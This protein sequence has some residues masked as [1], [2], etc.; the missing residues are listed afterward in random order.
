LH[1]DRVRYLVLL[2]FIAGCGL[3]LDLDPPDPD[4]GMYTPDSG[5][6][7][8]DAGMAGCTSIAECDDGDPCNGLETCVDGA[9]AGGQALDCDDGISCTIDECGAQGCT[10]TEGTCPD[11]GIACTIET[12]DRETDCR[13]ELRHDVCDDEIFCTIDSC[14]P[15]AQGGCE[16]TPVDE[17]CANGAACDPTNGCGIECE[18]DD[19]CVLGPCTE[20]ATCTMGVCER[21]PRAEGDL[22]DDANPCTA[23]SMCVAG[24]CRGIERTTCEG[25]PCVRCNAERDGCDGSRIAPIGAMC[26]DGDMC[27]RGDRCDGEGRCAPTMIH[28]CV[29]GQC[30]SSTCNPSTGICDVTFRTGPCDDN[31]ACTHGE[32]CNGG[33]CGLPTSVMLCSDADPCTIDRCNPMNG[34]CEFPIALGASCNDNNACTTNTTCQADGVCGGGNT[35]AS[36]TPCVIAICNDATTGCSERPAEDG[37]PC[38]SGTCFNGVC[39]PSI[40]PADSVRCADGMCCPLAQGWCGALGGTETC[41]RCNPDEIYCPCRGAGSCL[42]RG[43]TCCDACETIGRLCGAGQRC[44]DCGPSSQCVGTGEP[45]TCGTM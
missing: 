43:S 24:E 7:T 34:A 10:N 26:N 35:C 4:A 32:S 39:N 33:T 42:P 16:H 3:V 12:C 21:T 29:S 37:T 8:S 22:C 23:A 28:E 44:C 2:P 38:P 9:C 25:Q 40:C 30:F 41:V 45:C 13:T 15:E 6:G 14:N 5:G 19:E 18:T 11:D 36:S 27:T 20:T 17:R 1:S 31:S